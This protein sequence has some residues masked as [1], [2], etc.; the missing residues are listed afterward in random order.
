MASVERIKEQPSLYRRDIIIDTCIHVSKDSPEGALLQAPA[1]VN[2]V[3]LSALFKSV[4]HDR[5]GE[6]R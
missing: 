4:V 5:T 2:L 6:S 1:E 3:Q